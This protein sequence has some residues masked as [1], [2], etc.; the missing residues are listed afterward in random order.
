MDVRRKSATALA[1]L[2][3]AILD[4]DEKIDNRWIDDVV[5]MSVLLLV[6]HHAV[7]ALQF[8]QSHCSFKNG[9]KMR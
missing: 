4:D 9:R 8:M 5:V 2:R 6:T 7:I 1:T 3:R